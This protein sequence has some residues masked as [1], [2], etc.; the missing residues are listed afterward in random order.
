M[1][2]RY[3]RYD[4]LETI[5]KGEITMDLKEYEKVK[6]YTY[7]EYCDY[8]QQKYGVGLCDYMKPDWT[9]NNTKVTRTK[10]G[11]YVHHKYEDHAI[12]LGKPEFAKNNPYEW[13]K[14]E[15]LIYCNLLEHLLLHQLI[16]E[17]PAE[18]KTIKEK[19]GNGGIVQFIVPELNDVYSGWISKKAWEQNCHRAIINNKDVYLLILKRYKDFHNNDPFAILHLLKSHNEQF[20][21]WAN[22]NN[23]DLYKEI[24]SI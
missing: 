16:C 20:G 12:L 7:L 17:Y 14:K 23:S 6:N 9:K 2:R 11:L 3:E 24:I 5:E 19:V 8:L 13:Q 18:N 15:N 4:I 21:T 10:D 22:E 1:N